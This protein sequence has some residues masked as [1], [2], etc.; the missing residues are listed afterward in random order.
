MLGKAEYNQH[1]A[2]VDDP[3]PLGYLDDAIEA[4]ELA[5]DCEPR[6]RPGMLNY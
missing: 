1:R 4:I 3:Q 5:E 6:A 2:G